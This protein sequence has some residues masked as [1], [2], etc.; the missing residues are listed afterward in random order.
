MRTTNT[1]HRIYTITQLRGMSMSRYPPFKR[2]I[3]WKNPSQRKRVSL[4]LLCPVGGMAQKRGT[5]FPLY[6]PPPPKAQY[7]FFS[8]QFAGNSQ[9]REEGFVF[10]HDSRSRGDTRRDAPSLP[11]KAWGLRGRHWATYRRMLPYPREL[12]PHKLVSN[13]YITEV[14]HVFIS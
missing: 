3:N 1:F 7:W 6:H 8:F 4:S 11:R 5:P 14:V 12:R 2:E 10:R 13:E 9:E